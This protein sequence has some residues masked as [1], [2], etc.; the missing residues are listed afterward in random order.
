MGDCAVSAQRPQPRVRKETIRFTRGRHFYQ[1]ADDYRSGARARYIGLKDG[2]VA[3]SGD[4]KGAVM[5]M[6]IAVSGRVAMATAPRL[7]AKA[8]PPYP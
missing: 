5:G 8:W 6:L 2:R 4:D 1:I 3:A 7:P